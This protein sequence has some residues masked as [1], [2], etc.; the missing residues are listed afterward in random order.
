MKHKK[1]ILIVTLVLALL[2]LVTYGLCYRQLPAEIPMHFDLNGA[3]DRYGSPIELLV[4][5]FVPLMV[6]GLFLVMP[7]IDSKKENYEKFGAFY[8]TF[9]VMMVVFMDVVFFLI[10]ATALGAEGISVDKVVPVM[11]GVLLL[12]IGKY[13][14]G[15]K[16]NTSFG[17]KTR[18]TRGS[19]AVW[20]KT[21]LFGGYCFMVGG[22]M[23]LALT[24]L[25][26]S[27]MLPVIFAQVFILVIL[28]CAMAYVY[29][30]QE[31]RG[32]LK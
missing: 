22:V 31:L 10:L 15:I 23:M 1:S 14:P 25:P 7:R 29:H 21:H 17:I 28:P 2:P 27:L 32:T 8:T 3:V 30:I 13:M 16:S 6:G 24:F 18:W 26:T 12:V 4:L 5:A 11:V 20:D 19:E 9:Q